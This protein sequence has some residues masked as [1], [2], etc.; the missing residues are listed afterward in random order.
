MSPEGVP[1][2][3][4]D[5]D[6]DQTRPLSGLANRPYHRTLVDIPGEVP[7]T[8]APKGH[9]NAAHF[10]KS[11]ATGVGGATLAIRGHDRPR[12]A[13]LRPDA[14]PSGRQ[15]SRKAQ[16]DDVSIPRCSWTDDHRA[17]GR[18]RK[19]GITDE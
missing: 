6:D 2:E 16:H 15:R 7:A 14:R 11:G 18:L 10:R 3:V 1:P 17:T 19:A 9:R 12:E 8:L 13:A 4:R 5:S